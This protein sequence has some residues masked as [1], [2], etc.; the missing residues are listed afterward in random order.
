MANSIDW[1]TLAIGTL[2][3]VGC[4]KQIK[5]CA[6]VA[7]TTAASLASAAAV[8]VN[9]A[10]AQMYDEHDRVIPERA[11]KRAEQL[12]V[13]LR[14]D[15]QQHRAESVQRQSGAEEEA[16]VQPLAL[17]VRPGEEPAEQ[18]LQHPPA[19]SAEEKQIQNDQEDLKFGHSRPPHTHFFAFSLRHCRPAVKAKENSDVCRKVCYTVARIC[20]R[21]RLS[22][23]ESRL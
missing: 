12:M 19:N 17:R 4:R 14:E 20:R 10:A 18:K 7:A 5:S 23:A 15:E 6:K 22:C 21:S 8:A 1:G 2:I 3:G 11:R 9:S 13:Q 16:R